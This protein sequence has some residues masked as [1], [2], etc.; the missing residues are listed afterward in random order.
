MMRALS[1][2]LGIAGVALCLFASAA[3]AQSDLGRLKVCKVS[4]PGVPVGTIFTITADSAPP[5]TVTAGPAPDGYCSVGPT[6]PI[7][8]WVLVTEI[9]P[10]GT[11]MTG[12][13][14]N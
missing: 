6:F 11:Q 2:N 14:V 7:G 4:G 3:N 5:F 8:S 9:L 12:V 13:T 10:N 1:R